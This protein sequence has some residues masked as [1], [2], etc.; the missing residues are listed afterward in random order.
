[1]GSFVST[2]ARVALACAGALAALCASCGAPPPGSADREQPA[3]EIGAC[4]QGDPS[5]RLDG[6]AT[7]VE[8]VLPGTEHA[9]LL[10]PGGSVVATLHRP[11]PTARLAYLVVGMRAR[12]EPQ[13]ARSL[14]VAIEG[15]KR[16]V[17]TPTAGFQR[18]EV[19]ELEVVPSQGARVGARCL[20]GAFEITYVVGRWNG[21]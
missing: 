19:N 10:Q 4:L 1:M 15:G 6:D 3:I 21:D 5:C 9:V 2:D 18:I 12:G 20:A 17:L 8:S 13:D 7:P 14:E 16:A 11:S